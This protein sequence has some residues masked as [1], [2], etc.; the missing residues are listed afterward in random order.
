NDRT[1]RLAEVLAYSRARDLS[2]FTGCYCFTGSGNAL[3]AVWRE[4]GIAV[5]ASGPG[6]DL[7][8]TATVYFIGPHGIERYTAAPPTESVGSSTAYL[9]PGEISGWG[10]GIAQVVRAMLG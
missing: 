6:G 4:Y 2:A 9:P 8:H 5:A 1:I 10:K 3:R 7:V